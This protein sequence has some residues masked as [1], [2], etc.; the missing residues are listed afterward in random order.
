MF[1]TNSLECFKTFVAGKPFT[2]VCIS[3]NRPHVCL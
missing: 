1:D 2:D 3:P